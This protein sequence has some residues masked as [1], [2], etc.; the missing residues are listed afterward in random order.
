MPNW[1]S[2]ETQAK[3]AIEDRGFDVL[4]ANV[5]F[6]ANCPNIDLIVFAKTQAIYIQVK[7]SEKPAAKDSVIVDGSPWSEAQLREGAAIYNKHD[8][9]HASLI[10]VVDR[11]KTGETNFYVVPPETLE[12]LV[13][14]PALLLA[15]RPKRDGTQRSINFRK[16]VRRDVL[17]P[18]LD[19]WRL[20]GTPSR[21]PQSD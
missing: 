6:R 3:R 20:L 12:E 5:V 13:R 2:S 4:D 18:W 17:A 11:V 21:V 10:I 14:E 1:K 19:A 7:S 15:G 8:H 9:Y 16:E